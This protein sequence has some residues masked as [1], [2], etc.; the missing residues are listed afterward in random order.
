MGF[1]VVVAIKRKYFEKIPSVI[2]KMAGLCKG[3]WDAEAVDLD[4]ESGK[5]CRSGALMSK[6]QAV[7]S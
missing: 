6:P 4:V 3:C 2:I 1:F 7:P 5:S